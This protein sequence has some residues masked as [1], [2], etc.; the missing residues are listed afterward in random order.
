[1]GPAAQPSEPPPVAILCGGRGTR[2]RERTGEIP[3][4]LVEIGG[5]P[6][7]WHVVRLYAAQGFRRFV[8]CTGYRREMIEEFA[9]STAWPEPI[10]LECHDTGRDTPTG[11]RVRL[12]ADRLDGGAFNVAYADGLADIRFAELLAVHRDGNALATMTVVRP[13]SQ[14]GVAELGES[15]RVIGFE[16]KPPVD[17][18]VNGGFFCLEPGALAYLDESSTL[19]REPLRRLAADRQLQAYRHTGFWEC[20]DT[21]KDAV[22]LNDR[23]ARGEAPWVIWGQEEPRSGTRERAPSRSAPTPVAPGATGAGSPPVE[24]EVEGHRPRAAIDVG[25]SSTADMPETA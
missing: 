4:A 9:A 24:T 6:I 10:A 19:E 2:L 20:M 15:D 23:W 12:A 5:R 11:G 16:E 14:F 25:P 17:Q 21:Y 7:L 13:R 18:W 3:K 1:M 22:E 8:L